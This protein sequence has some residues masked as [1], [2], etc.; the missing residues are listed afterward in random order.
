M[1]DK[2]SII[3]K[4]TSAILKALAVFFTTVA[5]VVVALL[6]VIYVLVKGP[7]PTAQKLFVLSVRE[8]SAIGFLANIYLSD[9][10]LARLTVSETVKIPK[11][12]TDTSL[13]EIPTPTPSTEPN[14]TEDPE[15]TEEVKDIEVVRI[16]G[17]LYEGVMLIV[18]DPLRLFVGTPDELGGKGLKLVEMV[19]KYDA[20]A[21]IN[22]GGFYD[23]LGGGHEGTPDGMVICN[24]E[25]VWGEPDV[26]LNVAGFDDLGILHVGMMTTQEAMDA[27]IQWAVSF[28]PALII[29]GKVQSFESDLISGLNPRTAIGQRSDGAVLMLVVDGRR[30]NSLGATYGDLADIMLDFGAVNASNLDGGSSTLMIYEGEVLNVCASVTGPRALP[31]TFLVR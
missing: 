8:T 27:K 31:T 9:E 24:G 12:Q 3:K 16:S 22:A 13:I 1:T 29:N 4:T 28:G 6:G 2:R 17:S 5:L 21:G 15:P 23:P 25:V 20:V 14:G 10:E 19:D 30:M 7:S 18:K 11:E 26:K